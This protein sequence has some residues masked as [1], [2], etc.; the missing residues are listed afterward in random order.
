M[1]QPI[2][3]SNGPAARMILVGMVSAPE[4]TP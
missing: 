4:T 1:L 3:A 2:E